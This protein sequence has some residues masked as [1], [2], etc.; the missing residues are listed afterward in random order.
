MIYGSNDE[1][2]KHIQN[3][4][5]GK[6]E[7]VKYFPVVKKVVQQFDGKVYNCKLDKALKEA[8]TDEQHPYG[9]V[10]CHIAYGG[11][12]EIVAHGCNHGMSESVSILYIAKSDLKDGK[13]IDAAQ[14]L[15]HINNNYA[16]L[17]KEIS[18][19]EHDL[20]TIDDTLKQI[21]MLKKQIKTLVEPLSWTTR[22]AYGISRITV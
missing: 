19:L 3:R 12:I 15:E 8:T 22:D 14:W 7:L 4:I 9:A 17:M 20:E 16:G 1:R 6:K 11:W 2:R 13:R 18:G 21:E 10:Y 5:D